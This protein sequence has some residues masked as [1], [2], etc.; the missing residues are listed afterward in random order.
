MYISQNNCK[1]Q[2]L[3]KAYLN[4]MTNDRH[5]NIKQIRNIDKK[6]ASKYTNTKYYGGGIKDWWK[7]VKDFGKRIFTAPAKIA[8]AIYPA[9][10]KVIDFA[11]ENPTAQ[12]VISSIPKVGPAIAEG[13]K[14]AKSITDIVNNVIKAIQEKNPGVSVQEAKKLVESI[15]QTVKNVVEK[16]DLSQ[17]QKDKIEKT[18]DKIYK[19][20]PETIKSQGIEDVKKA[21]GYLPFLDISTMKTIERTGKGGRILAPKIRF[22]KPLFITKHKEFFKHLPEYNAE[23]VG[24]VGGAVFGKILSQ[25][26]KE[27]GRLKLAG[28]TTEPKTKVPNT[29]VKESKKD[30]IARIQSRRGNGG[31]LH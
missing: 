30:I 19:I 16:S 23:K 17:E 15:D 7:K 11:A 14:G 27:S 8:S 1:T 9:M 22:V 21:A 4:S 6:L 18:R 10:K 12:A 26:K 5:Y 3:R 13:I 25:P 29:E 28:D 20:L 24:K 31:R 2:G